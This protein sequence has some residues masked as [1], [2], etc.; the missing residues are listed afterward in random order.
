MK[1]SH[2]VVTILALALVIAAGA[3]LFAKN[4][5][6]LKLYSKVV[7]NGTPLDA[8]NYTMRWENHSPTLTVTIAKGKRVLATAQAKLVNRDK[9]YPYDCVVSTRSEDGTPIL[10]EVRFAGS[11]QVIVFSE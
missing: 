9:P 2:S 11:S 7:L 10:R 1:R 8:G 6:S 3:P 4:S 5:H